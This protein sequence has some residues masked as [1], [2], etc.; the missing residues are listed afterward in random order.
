MLQRTLF[1]IANTQTLNAF[2]LQLHNR[3][4]S[5]ALGFFVVFEEMKIFK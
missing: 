5:S 4:I 2:K 3:K 1:I